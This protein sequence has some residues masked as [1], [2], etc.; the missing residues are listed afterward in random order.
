[1][2]SIN[3]D[4]LIAR[5]KR[6]TR[7]SRDIRATLP[8]RRIPMKSEATTCRAKSVQSTR[9]TSKFGPKLERRYRRAIFFGRIS[10]MPTWWYPQ[11]KVRTRSIV[12]K[13]VVDHPMAHDAIVFGRSKAVI[14]IS[15]TSYSST[16][17][18]RVSQTRRKVQ[19]G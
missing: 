16:R 2:L 1:M 14:G 5:T 11:K 13:D 18:L 6:S 4:I 3:E 15:R 8:M 12:Q 7:K 17:R 10:R 19:F 9:T